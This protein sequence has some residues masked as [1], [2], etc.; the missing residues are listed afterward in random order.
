MTMLITVQANRGI[1]RVDGIDV[2]QLLH[3]IGEASA[4]DSSTALFGLLLRAQQVLAQV[5]AGGVLATT[6]REVALSATYHALND[7]GQDWLI[8][9]ARQL[10]KGFPRQR[11]ALTLVQLGRD[12]GSR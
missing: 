4:K 2:A 5:Q 9:F 7:A 11:V 12:R 3:A 1:A 10:Q 8:G 6:Q